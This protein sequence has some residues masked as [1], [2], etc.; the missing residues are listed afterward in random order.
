M[1]LHYVLCSLI[2]KINLSECINLK[3]LMI[4]QIDIN[5]IHDL[6]KII[7][8]KCIKKLLIGS[9]FDYSKCN[10]I[11]INNIDTYVNKMFNNLKFFNKRI[12]INV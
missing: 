4:A 8:P 11:D 6:I 12:I 7:L 9:I 10:T 5:S 2:N 1:Q 3:T